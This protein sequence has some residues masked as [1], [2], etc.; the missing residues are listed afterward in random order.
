[1][2]SPHCCQGGRGG[3]K[4]TLCERRDSGLESPWHIRALSNVC[5]RKKAGTD[6]GKP[7]TSALERRGK[8]N[9]VEAIRAEA[10]LEKGGS[11][12]KKNGCRPP[13]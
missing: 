1:M 9:R 2:I 4:R 5:Q 6:P 10:V 7:P 12:K 13:A 8:E 11:P 3:G